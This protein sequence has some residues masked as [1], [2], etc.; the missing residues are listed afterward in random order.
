M[1]HICSK[2]GIKCISEYTLNKHINQKTPCDVIIE[3]DRCK[4]TFIRLIDLERHK[5][6]KN[7]CKVLTKS[8]DLSNQLK[9]EIE[10]EKTLQK[11]KEL[12][13]KL[14][15]LELKKKKE[16]EIIKAKAEEVNNKIDKRQA[17]ENN[18][19]QNELML[20]QEKAKLQLA[21][22]EK[23]EQLKTERKEKTA[24][25][26]KK[27]TTEIDTKIVIQFINEN[28]KSINHTVKSMKELL[29]IFYNDANFGAG[30]DEDDCDKNYT[31][32]EIFKNNEN[33]IGMTKALIIYYYGNPDYPNE[34]CLYYYKQL[35]NFYSFYE[36]KNK[37]LKETDFDKEVQPIFMD[38]FKKSCECMEKIVKC[39]KKLI[40]DE[41][42]FINFQSDIHATIKTPSCIRKQ[43][44]E[45][46]E[47]EMSEKLKMIE[48]VETQ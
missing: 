26:I 23:I 44:A 6:R 22:A 5:A 47:I 20:I 40:W 9:L 7:P 30:L 4:K 21:K 45:V 11:D 35:D 28:A 32:I 15:I 18:R 27:N 41:E 38:I 3:C 42:K 12:E 17:F 14:A 25:T 8:K 13:G 31:F 34:G 29:E 46:F 39:N 1:S 16:I 24:A 48:S 10:K 2:C 19:V 33:I 43:F 37:E 36:D